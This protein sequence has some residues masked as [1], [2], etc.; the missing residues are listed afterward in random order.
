MAALQ[1]RALAAHGMQVL[2]PDLLGCGDS[3]GDFGDATWEAWVDDLVA[4][5]N[6]MQQRSE[7]PLWLWGL[8]AGC[9]LA[10]EAMRRLDE[11]PQLLLWAPTAAGRPAAQQFIRLAA[12]ADL[13]GG[14][15]KGILEDLRQQIARGES[16]EI[17]GYR[18]SAQLLQA[19]EKATLQPDPRGSRALWFDLSTQPD[20]PPSP[21]AAKTIQAWNA[22]GHAIDARMVQGPAFWQTVEIEEAPELIR[23]TTQAMLLASAKDPAQ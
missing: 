7:A 19:L 9:L 5:C 13:S 12:A 20:A 8:R 17:A 10:V 4:A 6:W 2:Q 23:T 16:V 22:A 1:A 18:I 15:A 14:N 11:P 3:S 21:V